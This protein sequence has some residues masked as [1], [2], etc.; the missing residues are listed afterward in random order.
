MQSHGMWLQ[1]VILQKHQKI[2]LR[3]DH[4]AYQSVNTCWICDHITLENTTVH[5]AYSVLQCIMTLLCRLLC[6]LVTDCHIPFVAVIMWM[7]CDGV[8]NRWEY[9]QHENHRRRQTRHEKDSCRPRATLPQKPWPEGGSG[10]WVWC[11]LSRE[12]PNQCQG[13][14]ETTFTRLARRLWT[15]EGWYRH[16]SAPSPSYEDNATIHRWTPF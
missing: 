3:L 4:I 6:K 7:F 9:V 13:C 16:A 10:G 15:E 14:P 12:S 8:H 2:W 5:I 1:W 11:K